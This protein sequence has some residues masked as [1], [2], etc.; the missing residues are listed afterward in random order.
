M[1]DRQSSDLRGYHTRTPILIHGKRRRDTKGQMPGP[2]D[3]DIHG[4]RDP[5]TPPRLQPPLHPQ[6]SEE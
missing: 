2:F 6:A 5:E 3:S 4:A 1:K